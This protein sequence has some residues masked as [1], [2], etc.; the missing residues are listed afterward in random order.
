MQN[1]SELSLADLTSGLTYL[2]KIGK[3]IYWGIDQRKQGL[4]GLHSKEELIKIFENI[5]A[6][7]SKLRNEIHKRFAG[8]SDIKAL[9]NGSD[10]KRNNEKYSDEDLIKHF[11]KVA[12]PIG[13]IP[14]L[15]DLEKDSASKPTW[16]R[17]LKNKRFI[18]ALLDILSNRLENKLLTNDYKDQIL[19][20]KLDVQVLANKICRKEIKNNKEEQP[21]KSDYREVPYPKDENFSPFQKSKN[22]IRVN[23]VNSE[24]ENQINTI[25]ESDFDNIGIND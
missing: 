2:E 6:E 24:Y 15:E 11:L 5:S 17:R 18:L 4:E 7:A 21:D 9:A 25:N 12:I 22:G 19:R 8:I 16:S 20:L 14:K 23:R 10:E 13:E 1:I 3:D